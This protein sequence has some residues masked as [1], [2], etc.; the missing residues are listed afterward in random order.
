MDCE[1]KVI[2]RDGTIQSVSFDKILLR[3]KNLSKNELVVNYTSLVQKIID[4]IYNN[5]NTSEIDELLAQQCASLSTSHPD[6]QILAGRILTSNLQKN[7]PSTFLNAMTILYNNTDLDGVHKPIISPTLFNIASKYSE[8]LE[9]II[10]YQRDFLIDYF[11]LKTLERAYLMKKDNKIIERPQHM[12]MRVAI[13]IHNDNL[14][15]IKNTYNL[16]SNKYFTHATPTLFNA[17]T[18]RPQLSSCYLLAMEDDSID[19]IYN[20]LKDCAKISKWA[21]GI[22]LHVHNIR[23][24]GTRINGTN[25][26]SNGLVPMLRVFNNTARYVDQGGGRRN[27]SFAIYLTPWH[28]VFLNF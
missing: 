22:G 17:G 18:N 24:S 23:A 14:D 19:G 6:Y 12:W 11:G 1:D 25:G 2:K 15:K 3:V 20:T 16:L 28:G 21:G 13:G 27:G 8:E 5:I 7:T 9:E 26:T 10:D 4:R